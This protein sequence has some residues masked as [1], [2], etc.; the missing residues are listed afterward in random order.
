MSGR[1][2]IWGIMGGPDFWCVF[3]LLHHPAPEA[4]L[5]YILPTHAPLRGKFPT[6]QAAGGLAHQRELRR[7][8]IQEMKLSRSFHF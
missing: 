5:E 8:I 1:W 6:G 7:S 3:H 4:A 2:E